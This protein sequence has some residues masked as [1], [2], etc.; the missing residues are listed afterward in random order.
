MRSVSS[1]D[2]NGDKNYE[3]QPQFHQTQLQRPLSENS[4]GHSSNE[5]N[6]SR[7]MEIETLKIPKGLLKRIDHSLRAK[8]MG[9]PVE[10]GEE[11]SLED[12]VQLMESNG[13]SLNDAVDL[14]KA[15]MQVDQGGDVPLPPC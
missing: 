5:G 12:Q 2:K 13:S 1:K 7:S 6:S 4:N 9:K 14:A 11:C 3:K 10:E 8:N 15:G